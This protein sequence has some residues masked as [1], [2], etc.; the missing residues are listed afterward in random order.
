LVQ[1]GPKDIEM[2]PSSLPRSIRW[3]FHDD[4]HDDDNL[5]NKHRAASLRQHGYLFCL[6][7]CHSVLCRITAR[8]ISRFHWNLVYDW[9]I[10][11]SIEQYLL[12]IWSQITNKHRTKTTR[13]NTLPTIVGTRQLT[14]YSTKVIMLPHRIIIIMKLVTWYTTLAVDGWVVTFGTAKRGL[15]GLRPH[16]V[17]SLLYQMYTHQR[18]V[19]QSPYCCSIM[20]C[21]TTVFVCQLKG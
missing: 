17:P 7:F 16:P 3:K 20:V 19:Y 13:M 5:A 11:Q 18:P 9:P 21:C 4:D 1:F 6:S 15:G 2:I 8:V 10:Y 14:L 12:V